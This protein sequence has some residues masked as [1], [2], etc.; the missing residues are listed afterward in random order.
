MKKKQRVKN[1]LL[2]LAGFFLILLIM[3][4]YQYLRIKKDV[5]AG[6]VREISDV[7][8]SELQSFFSDITEKL[9]LLRDWGKNDVLFD[10][11]QFSLNSKFIPFLQRT[12]YV[13]AVVLANDQG[14]E[15]F[16]RRQGGNYLT[17]ITPGA[18]KNEQ[19]SQ[20]SVWSPE[21]E[22]LQSW[23]EQQQYDPR[24][25][26]WFVQTREDEDVHW[27]G[28]YTFFQ[29]RKK[30][31]TASVSWP[32]GKDNGNFLILGIDI[33]VDKIKEILSAR[34]SGRPG[35]LFLT[36]ED[37]AFLAGDDPSG[38]ASAIRSEDGVLARLIAKWRQ[39]GT[40]SQQ[41]SRD[42]LNRHNWLATFQKLENSNGIFW[43][44]Y[45][46]PEKELLG[47]IDQ[48]LFSVDLIELVIA[49]AG[50]LLILVLSLK[51][52]LLHRKSE[53]ID[54]PLTRLF[55]AISK[56]EGPDVEFKS[57]IRVNLKSG[58]LGKEIELAW[59]KGVVA[60]LNS[61]GGTL[62]LGVNDSGQIT[63]LAEDGFE[64]QDRCLLHVKN[65]VNQ[66]IGAE[67]SSFFEASLVQCEAHQVVMLEC[68]PAGE[69]VFLKI[70]KNEE[71]YIR[72]GPSSIKLSPSQMVSYV[73]QKSL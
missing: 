66:H 10:G 17:R 73:Q 52:D 39:A 70:G 72:S 44:G 13:S 34:E 15:Y 24:E 21:L 65:L 28:L 2:P 31:I 43:I 50:S 64:N 5:T 19:L 30:G 3:N 58:K 49:A 55:S 48:T 29:S 14:R 60:F 54:P 47:W 37:G 57:T 63:G 4:G 45:A 1:I 12:S 7:E 56:G 46:A 18:E 59:L 71:F 20:F 36:R 33:S 26:P 61:S 8:V 62:L 35:I 22:K 67:F 69:A 25:K 23:Q 38:A 68:R 9:L 41:L 32:T 11:D 27:T 42:S 16:I 6:L 51:F 40:P 53:P